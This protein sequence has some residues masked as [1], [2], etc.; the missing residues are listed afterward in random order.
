MTFYGF[1]SE[2]GKTL[3]P[4]K[5]RRRTY[6][7]IYT[8][9]VGV[10]NGFLRFELLFNRVSLL[11]FLLFFPRHKDSIHLPPELLLISPEQSK[12]ELETGYG[13]SFCTLS[14]DPREKKGG[15]VYTK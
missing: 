4:H 12:I 5:P 13:G 1:L 8:V 14:G 10:E 15:Q 3:A 2:R 6:F 7:H 11:F 9:T